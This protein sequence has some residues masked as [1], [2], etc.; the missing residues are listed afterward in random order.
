MYQ[1]RLKSSFEDG[2]INIAYNPEV[3]TQEKAKEHL[4][5]LIGL[6]D[7]ETDTNYI[8][9]IFKQV[10]LSAWYEAGFKDVTEKWVEDYI[11]KLDCFPVFGADTS[12]ECYRFDNAEQWDAY[13]KEDVEVK[14]YTGNFDNVHS[15]EEVEL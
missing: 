14:V 3:F 12:L 13:E 15:W 5:C 1:I 6:E 8:I 4:D 11:S 10:A 7:F 2:L 9:E